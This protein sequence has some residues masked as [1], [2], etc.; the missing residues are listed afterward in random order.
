MQGNT[1]SKGNRKLAEKGKGKPVQ[2]GKEKRTISI[3]RNFK[4]DYLAQISFLD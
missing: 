3:L 2:K 4:H 1:C